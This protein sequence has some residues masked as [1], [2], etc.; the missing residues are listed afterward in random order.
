MRGL[1]QFVLCLGAACAA[2]A[3]PVDFGKAEFE[4][5]VAE[6]NLARSRLRLQTEVSADVPESFQ[7][8]GT[9]VSGGDLRGLMYGLLE[10]AGQVRSKGRLMAAKGRPAV[11]LRGVRLAVEAGDLGSDWFR[12]REQWDELF[13]AMARSRL[14]RMNPVLGEGVLVNRSVHDAL[15]AI[16]DSAAGFAVDLAVT[17]EPG[18]LAGGAPELTSLLRACASVRSVGLR[19]GPGGPAKRDALVRAIAQAGRRVV[20]EVPQTEVT[21][22]LLGEIADTG[23]PYRLITGDSGSADLPAG[24]SELLRDLGEARAPGEGGAPDADRIRKIVSAADTAGF[25]LAIRSP[26]EIEWPEVQLWG[27]MGYSPAGPPAPAK[28]AAAPRKK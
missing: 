18:A 9:R 17:L 4:R 21:P 27:R 8:V 11:P 10:A 13:A 15:R 23:V 2:L 5:A 19:T 24:R 1:R 22:G 25:E 20:L 14:N 28:P 26:S 3:G 7:I 6:R 16:S 12:R